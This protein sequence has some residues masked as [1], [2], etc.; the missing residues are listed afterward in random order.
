MRAVQVIA[1]GLLVLLGLQS[2]GSR[3]LLLC[4]CE[5]TPQLAIA[6]CCASDHSPADEAVTGDPSMPADD[7]Q[8]CVVIAFGIDD[9]VILAAPVLSAGVVP[10]RWSEVLVPLP[11]TSSARMALLPRPPLLPN[12]GLRHLATVRLT[13]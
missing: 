10:P 1:I 2:V 3:A 4:L 5:P 7:C 12:P 6:D 11:A 13:I 8:E 9:A